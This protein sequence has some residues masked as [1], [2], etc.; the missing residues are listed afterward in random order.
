MEPVSLD[1]ARL[2][3]V[4]NLLPDTSGL[5]PL[6]LPEEFLSRDNGSQPPPSPEA[7]LRFQSA[8]S[9]EARTPSPSLSSSLSQSI[10]LSA[11]GQPAPSAP[12]TSLPPADPATAPA[13]AP[14]LPLPPSAPPR[15]SSP[16]ASLPSDAT[17]TPRESSP[18]ASLPR[19]KAVETEEQPGESPDSPLQALPISVPA[20]LDTSISSP[21][22]SSTPSVSPARAAMSAEAY[23]RNTGATPIPAQTPAPEP[24]LSSPLRASESPRDAS[25]SASAPLHATPVDVPAPAASPA[26]LADPSAVAS[27]ASARTESIAETVDQIASAVAS[28]ILVTPSLRAGGDGQIRIA[29]QP[30]VLDGSTVTLTARNGTLAVAVVPA[31]AEAAALAAAA[32]PQLAA[33]MEAHAPAFRRVQVSL[34]SKKGNPDETV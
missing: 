15:E 3:T 8:L 16:I 25:S 5:A 27:A 29:L 19:S 24:W 4:D 14:S 6:S 2:S 18:I 7:I 31:T 12:S 9:D 26:P 32:L 10:L 17:A 23:A 28:R 11:A 30:A 22:P 21:T 13:T 34:A 20:P 1:F 33:A